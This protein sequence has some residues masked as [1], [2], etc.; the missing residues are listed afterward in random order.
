M[1]FLALCRRNQGLFRTKPT[2]D[3][4]KQFAMHFATNTRAQPDTFAK[5]IFAAVKALNHFPSIAEMEELIGGI[6]GLETA[7]NS[8]MQPAYEEFRPKVPG[9]KAAHEGLIMTYEDRGYPSPSGLQFCKISED[10]FFEF[11]HEWKNGRFHPAVN[12]IKGDEPI[13]INS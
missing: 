3:Y 5:A 6:I 12:R 1:E 13:K 9:Y 7:R 4:L 11:Y 10:E 8:M 2:D